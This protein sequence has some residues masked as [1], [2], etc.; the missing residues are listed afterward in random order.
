MEHNKYSLLS[1]DF[2]LAVPENLSTS[3]VHLRHTHHFIPEG[4][5]LQLI[6]VPSLIDNAQ[7]NADKYVFI[8]IHLI[9]TIYQIWKF[10]FFLNLYCDPDGGDLG[11]IVRKESVQ[12]I[13]CKYSSGRVDNSFYLWNHVTWFTEVEI[14]R[15]S[16]W[17]CAD[18]CQYSLIF[19]SRLRVIFNTTT[20]LVDLLGVQYMYTPMLQLGL[21]EPIT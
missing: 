21:L 14:L 16:G 11:D 10:S 4:M 6:S 3:T 12:Q 2:S 13:I 18:F 15:G 19:L 17:S 7:F 1:T 5:K 20:H 8:I 9:A